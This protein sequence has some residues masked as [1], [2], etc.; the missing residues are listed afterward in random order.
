[1]NNQD[2]LEEAYPD[3]DPVEEAIENIKFVADE[4]RITVKQSFEAWYSDLDTNAFNN[5]V[6]AGLALD[7]DLALIYDTIDGSDSPLEAILR[8]KANQ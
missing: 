2:Y 8:L 3:C 4:M 5:A 7:K 1:M 6:F